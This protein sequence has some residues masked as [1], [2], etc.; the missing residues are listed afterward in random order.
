[1]FKSAGIYRITNI[2]N[3]KS[4]VGSSQ[5]LAKRWNLHR[6]DLVNKSHHSQKLQRAWDKYGESVFVFDVIE[7]VFQKENLIKREQKYIDEFDA[8]GKGYNISPTAGNCAGIKRSAEFK[9]KVSAGMKGIKHSTEAI[10]KMSLSKIGKKATQEHRN[11]ISA[12]KMGNKYM[13]GKKHTEES[14]KKMCLAHQ[15]R[16]RKNISKNQ[17]EFPI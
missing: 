9:N 3:G 1:M 17:M 12:L 4:Y 5:D 2:I 7:Y 15:K 14:I 16:H 11:K 6:K 13:L 8:V 10:K